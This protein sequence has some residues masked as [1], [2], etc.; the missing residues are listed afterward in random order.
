MSDGAVG[1]HLLI[2]TAMVLL[3]VEEDTSIMEWFMIK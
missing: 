1:F 2:L 3:R